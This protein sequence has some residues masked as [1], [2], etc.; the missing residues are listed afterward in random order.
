MDSLDVLYNVEIKK[1]KL[2]VAT[3]NFSGI[4][5][6]PFEYDDGSK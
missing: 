5:V 2:V 3:L 6:N 4:N 1:R